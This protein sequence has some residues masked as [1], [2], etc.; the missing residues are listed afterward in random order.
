MFPFFS[1]TSKCPNLDNQAKIE[2]GIQSGSATRL[3]GPQHPELSLPPSKGM[4]QQA[5]KIGARVKTQ[6][7][8]HSCTG[9]GCSKW[10][11]DHYAIGLLAFAMQIWL[12]VSHSQGKEIVQGW[13]SLVEVTLKY[14]TQYI[15]IWKP[16]TKQNRWEIHDTLLSR[17]S[18]LCVPKLC[19][20]HQSRMLN[21]TPSG[22]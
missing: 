15:L 4:H 14:A 19:S 13:A 12:N 21:G 10:C 18:S 16:C 11:H 22:S 20:C 2:A 17:C 6:R 1:F 9:C 8:G 5:A 3:S 7:P